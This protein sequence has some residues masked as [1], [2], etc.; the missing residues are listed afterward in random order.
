[1]ES[2]YGSDID[3]L[4]WDF[5]LM[6]PVDH[7]R[8]Q[9]W[10][11]RAGIHPTKPILFMLESSKV[12]GRFNRF[13]DLETDG[14]A[15]VLMNSRALGIL[16]NRLPRSNSIPDQDEIPASMDADADIGGEMNEIPFALE[17][18]IC[19][20][21]GYVEGSIACDDPMKHGTCNADDE[22][23]CVK[24]K[25][26]TRDKCVDAKY[27]SSWYPGWKTHLLRGHLLGQFLLNTMEDSILELHR[28]KRMQQDAEDDPNVIHGVPTRKATHHEQWQVVYQALQFQEEVD[29]ATF[30]NS[31]PVYD[32]WDMN[33][34]RSLNEIGVNRLFR[35]NAICRTALLPSQER[36]EGILDKSHKKATSYYEGYQ[37]G[38]S[39]FLL[40]TPPI[41]GTT[42]PL[43]YNANDRQACEHLEIDHKDFF[44]V[45]EGDGWLSTTAPHNSEIE[46]YGKN[47]NVEGVIVVCLKLCPYGICPDESIGFGT[48]Q[49]NTNFIMMNINGQKVSNVTQVDNS[50]CYL[51]QNSGGYVWERSR[52]DSLG[53]YK[54]NMKVNDVGKG[55]SLRISSIIVF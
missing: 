14:M 52:N 29:R 53:Q 45:R 38:F 46:A 47:L 2:V 23:V 41:K 3:V 1:M 21:D 7:H 40:G 5:S 25:F 54:L 50:A 39:Q 4:N 28:L 10:A 35:T 24:N 16:H 44:L 11:S 33:N 49:R 48:I 9:L 27:Q 22:S 55:R 51:L 19:D 42:M 34:D 36:Y 8:V 6:D 30:R 31:N 18:F 17:H 26:N 12:S 32:A 43:V 13:S 15:A 20:E 37:K